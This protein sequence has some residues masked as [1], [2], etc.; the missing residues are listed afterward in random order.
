M[1][2]I[3]A[4]KIVKINP[5]VISAGGSGLNLNAII[6][7]ESARVPVG[8]IMSF[9]SPLAVSDFFGASSDEAKV[10]NIYFSGFTNSNITPGAIKF[11]QFNVAAVPAYLRS[12][13]VSGFTLTQLQ[14]LSGVLSVT[15]DGSVE[16]SA[17]ISLAAATSFSNAATLIAAGFTLP[18]FAVTYD[19]QSGAF[20]FTNTSTGV[21]STISFATGTLSAGLL[22]TQATG[23]VLSQGADAAVIATYMNAIIS[24]DTNWATFMTIF[25]PD[26][27]GNTNKLEFANWTNAQ[28]NRYLY[29]CWDTDILPTE[30][31]APTSLG[32]ILKAD[33]SSGT[34]PLYG[35]DYTKAAFVCGITA[36]IDYTQ[37]QGATAFAFRMQSGLI[38]DVTDPTVAANLEENDYNYYG[39]WATA[40][41]GFEFL[42]PGSVTG[43]FAWIDSYVN[44]IWLN[45]SFQLALMEMLV[46]LKSVPYD[47]VGYAYQRAY[48]M[49]P[50]NQG[51]QFGMYAGGIP[52]SAAQILQVN[53]QAGLTIDKTLSSQGWYLQIL[54]A[55]PAVRA[56]RGSNPINF[57]YMQAGSVQ[58]ISMGS[59]AI[60]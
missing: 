35:L 27:S 33:G 9:V 60:Q 48:L 4:S 58:R 26:S 56:A 13:K 30:G 11:A 49:D 42:Y 47:S 55:S 32:A 38:P 29:A 43:P 15:I 19:S 57:W 52:L 53:T 10:A 37:I 54:P 36:S 21:T 39:A 3:P 14:A 1:S 17:A 28:N 25:N 24:Q 23:A 8:A 59:I 12:G 51:L 50:I 16:T 18:G 45:N 34:V 40:N 22:L 7:T 46:N 6:L 31:A 5:Q 44:E 41:Q 20:V 2:T